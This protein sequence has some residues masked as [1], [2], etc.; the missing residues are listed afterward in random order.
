MN[1]SFD[2]TSSSFF[3]EADT[4]TI[5]SCYEHTGFAGP[6]QQDSPGDNDTNVHQLD[7]EDAARNFDQQNLVL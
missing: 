7:L 4:F 2:A 5:G 1:E 6:N 3:D